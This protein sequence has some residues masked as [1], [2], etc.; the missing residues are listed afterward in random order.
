MR[1]RRFV[2]RNGAQ[3][4]E[5]ERAGRAQIGQGALDGFPCGVLREIGAQDHLKRRLAGHQCCGP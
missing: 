2:E 1:R 4:I 3:P 5:S